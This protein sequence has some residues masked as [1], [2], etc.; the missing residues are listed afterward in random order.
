MVVLVLVVVPFQRLK[1]HTLKCVS[2]AIVPSAPVGSYTV[3]ASE[4]AL[5]GNFQPKN[6]LSMLLGSTADSI[7]FDIVTAAQ[8]PDPFICLQ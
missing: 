8:A 5:R 1:V 3:V 4:S 7:T 6:V 2:L